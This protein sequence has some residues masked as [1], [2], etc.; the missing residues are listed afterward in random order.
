MMHCISRSVE[1]QASAASSALQLEGML[2]G[3]VAVLQVNV[4]VFVFLI[5][6]DG[7][8]YFYTLLCNIH[9]HIS[10]VIPHIPSFFHGYTTHI[11]YC[12]VG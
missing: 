12:F 4:L 11:M 6:K 8:L 9:Y 1:W 10:T 2:K 3:R 7:E 5:F